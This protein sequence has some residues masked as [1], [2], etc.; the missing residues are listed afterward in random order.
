MYVVWSRVHFSS[1]RRVLA[2][3]AVRGTVPVDVLLLLGDLGGLLLLAVVQRG[4]RVDRAVLAVRVA[5]GGLAVLLAVGGNFHVLLGSVL[6]ALR[7]RLEAEL[8]HDGRRRGRLWEVPWVVTGSEI[9]GE[10]GGM[11]MGK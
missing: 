10:G 7:L 8:L 6:P 5:V 3:V 1:N 11:R 4:G 2:N 9:G